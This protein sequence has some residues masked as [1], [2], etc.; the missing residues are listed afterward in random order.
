MLDTLI[1]LRALGRVTEISLGGCFVAAP[2]P[3]AV[4]SVVQLGLEH[5]GESFTTW[6]RVIYDRSVSGVG[7]RFIALAPDQEK[8][9]ATWL[10]T[11]ERI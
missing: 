11:L 3:P 6:A 5:N 7:L 1:K 10:H 4:S 2:D 9:L 8:I